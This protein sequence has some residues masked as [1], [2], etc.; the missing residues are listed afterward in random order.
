MRAL[1][2]ADR[3]G[4]GREPVVAAADARRWRRVASGAARHAAL[5]C[6]GAP[7]PHRHR[8]RH[9]PADAR[10]R[11]PRRRR[12]RRRGLVGRQTSR[13]ARRA[14]SRPTGRRGERFTHDR[15]LDLLLLDDAR[16]IHES[17]PIQPLAGRVARHA[18]PDLARGWLSRARRPR[19][20]ATRRWSGPSERCGGVTGDLDLN[21]YFERIAWAGPD[22]RADATRS[23]QVCSMH[24]M[25]RIPFENFDVLLG[26]GARIARQRPGQARSCPP[27]RLLLRARDAV[28]CGARGDRFAR[29][30]HAARV[31]LFAARTASMRTHMFLSVPLPEGRFVVDPGFG[32]LVPRLP[33]PLVEGE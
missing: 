8:R 25:L 24:H 29:C 1:V 16:V 30:R 22:A 19:R 27:R 18:G 21:A 11:A 3:A 17:T 6:R 2:R 7:V 32:A 5:V 20:C 9:R 28:P 4:R 12:P 23:C 15:T 14:S 31:V 26:H 10:R 33:L 13:A